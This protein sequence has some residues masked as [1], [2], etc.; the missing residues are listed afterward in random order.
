VTNK[1]NNNNVNKKRIQYTNNA[2]IAI[3][4]DVRCAVVYK[5]RMVK[6]EKAIVTTACYKYVCVCVCVYNGCFRVQRFVDEIVKIRLY[7][8]TV[9]YAVAR[10]NRSKDDD[11]NII[12]HIYTK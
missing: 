3:Q 9:K 12:L 6:A 1:N 11:Y 5:K 10:E 7:Y 4:R 2:V 8:K